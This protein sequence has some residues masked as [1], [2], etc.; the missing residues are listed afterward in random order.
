MDAIADAGRSH[1]G[2]GVFEASHRERYQARSRL[3]QS[4]RDRDAQRERHRGENVF[5]R[6]G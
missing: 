3:Q 4:R 6:G 2:R 5:P 1:N